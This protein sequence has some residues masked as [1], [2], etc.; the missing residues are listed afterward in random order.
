MNGQSLP[1]KPCILPELTK[2]SAHKLTTFWWREL[3]RIGSQIEFFYFY[4]ATRVRLP[5]ASRP[6]LTG[7]KMLRLIAGQMGLGNRRAPFSQC[8]RW[9]RRGSRPFLTMT[10]GALGGAVQ[11][12]KTSWRPVVSKAL[13]GFASA[14]FKMSGLI[15]A[16]PPPSLFATHRAGGQPL[17]WARNCGST[18]DRCAPRL[19]G[20]RSVQL[21]WRPPGLSA[22]GGWW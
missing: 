4:D 2:H 12:C 18:R 20:V 16:G 21:S 22:R 6:T 19:L 8:I 15:C 17:R 1:S 5:D 14:Y 10:H 13:T 3:N 11:G 9:D 7:Q